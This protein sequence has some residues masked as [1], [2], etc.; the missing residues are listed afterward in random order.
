MSRYRAAAR[1]TNAYKSKIGNK[2]PTITQRGIHRSPTQDMYFK[3]ALFLHTLRGIVN[4]DPRWWQ[5][6]RDTYATFKDK[7]IM[8]EDIVKF[9]NAQLK[10]DLTPVFNQYLRRAELPRLELTF[11]R[12]AGKGRVPL[13]RRRAGLRDAGACGH[14]WPPARRAADHRL[15]GDAEP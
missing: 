3:G 10:Q 5:L 4:D 8:T 6:V 1:I 12:A 9:F 14:A 11:D 2:E 15:A 13:A 7:N